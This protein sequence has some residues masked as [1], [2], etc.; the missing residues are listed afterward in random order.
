MASIHLRSTSGIEKCG[1]PPA[2]P[3]VSRA[4]CTD[5]PTARRGDLAF[6]PVERDVA[7]HFVREDFHDD[8]STA[9]DVGGDK[10]TRHAA[11]RLPVEDVGVWEG[12]QQ[13]VAEHG[14]SHAAK[15]S[16]AALVRW[17]CFAPHSLHATRCLAREARRQ[18]EIAVS[19]VRARS[20]ARPGTVATARRERELTPGL[21]HDR[22]RSFA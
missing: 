20:G 17:R 8:V 22:V 18:R 19:T 16:T 11:A 12:A 9:R 4:R 13:L 5:A 7:E 21:L 14:L 10:D 3:A 6:E 2:S 15:I 1:K